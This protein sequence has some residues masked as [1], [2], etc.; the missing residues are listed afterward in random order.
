[1]VQLRAEVLRSLCEKQPLASS[2]QFLAA[3]CGYAAHL[4]RHRCI[5]SSTSRQNYTGQP[6]FFLAE[7]RTYAGFHV[8]A[9]NGRANEASHGEHL[10]SWSL[11]SALGNNR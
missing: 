10:D 6:L 7:Q 3:Y 9:F 1:M 5:A 11:R 4:H 8:D 2:Y